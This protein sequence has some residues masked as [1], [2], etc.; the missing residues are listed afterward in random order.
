ML[1][2]TRKNWSSGREHQLKLT[3]VKINHILTPLST[4][5]S[6]NNVDGS[7]PK[8]KRQMCLLNIY[9]TAMINQ[10]QESI[11]QL[12]FVVIVGGIETSPSWYYR[13]RRESTTSVLNGF[14]NFFFCFLF[15]LRRVW[16][17]EW[18]SKTF[19]DDVANFSF[20][21]SIFNARTRASYPWRFNRDS[22]LL[23][24]FFRLLQCRHIIIIIVRKDA[25]SAKII[26]FSVGWCST[27]LFLFHFFEVRVCRIGAPCELS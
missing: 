17:E 2:N 20:I 18:K 16:D 7:C 22:H 27:N 3:K 23:F 5:I 19:A 13:W 21:Q 8:K 1:S 15:L 14:Q 11:A 6:T 4:H 9:D 10:T 26:V 25:A 12:E 24:P